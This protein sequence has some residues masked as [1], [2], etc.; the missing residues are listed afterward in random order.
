[1]GT[2]GHGLP[3]AGG[4]RCASG[5]LGGGGQRLPW[6]RGAAGLLEEL[7][8]LE[9]REEEAGEAAA[10]AAVPV[11]RS[12]APPGAFPPAPCHR[13]GRHDASPPDVTGSGS[14]SGA[15]PRPPAPAPRVWCNTPRAAPWC[16]GGRAHRHHPAGPVTARDRVT[17][18]PGEGGPGDVARACPEAAA[19][20]CNPSL[21]AAAVRQAPGPFPRF[22]VSREWPL[23]G[24]CG[25]GPRH[26]TESEAQRSEAACP[27]P[28][29]EALT[30]PLGPSA[31]WLCCL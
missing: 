30:G 8:S 24:P 17:G 4:G 10:G 15:A 18:H 22:R 14:A 5:H 27:P 28:P 29:G 6:E 7:R 19:A 12:P 20:G 13:L 21:R 9:P 2:A 11:P 16:R 25:V 3:G 31:G 1:M 26:T 23:R